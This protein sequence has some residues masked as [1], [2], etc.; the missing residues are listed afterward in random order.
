LK[1]VL[2]SS[3]PDVHDTALYFLFGADIHC[4]IS[5]GKNKKYEVKMNFRFPR[6]II[7][8]LAVIT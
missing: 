7:N 3:L 4:V 1:F 5:G 8:L 2:L 6:H